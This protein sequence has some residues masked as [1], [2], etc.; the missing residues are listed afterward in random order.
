MILISPSVPK[1]LGELLS[2]EVSPLPEE[3]GSDILFASKHGLVG[4]QRKDQKDFTTSL[5]DGRL[6]YEARLMQEKLPFRVLIL[7][8]KLLFH[9][10]ILYQDRRPTRFTKEAIRNLLRSLFYQRGIRVEFAD[11]LEDTAQIVLE[12]QG[13]FDEEDHPSLY[14]RPK[15]PSQWGVATLDEEALWILQ[16]FRG[17]GLTSARKILEQFGKIPLRWT[18]S[19]EELSKLIGSKRAERLFHLLKEG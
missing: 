5:A 17:I 13:Y 14:Q 3:Y 2:A 1:K 9:D 11:D 18:C 10:N 15:V 16:G 4:I 8:G 7:E 6:Q 12:L 19:K